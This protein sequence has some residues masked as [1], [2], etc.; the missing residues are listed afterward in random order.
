M[1][2]T[3]RRI[4]IA[5]QL[6]LT[7]SF[8][9][10]QSLD[11]LIDKGQHLL[12]AGSYDSA[13]IAFKKIYEDHRDVIKSIIGMADAYLKLNQYD[14]AFHF[15]ELA[16]KSLPLQPDTSLL[17]HIYDQQ[18]VGY[19]QIA[20]FEKANKLILKSLDLMLL[21]N[22]DSLMAQS[23]INLSSI[24]VQLSNFKKQRTYLELALSKATEHNQYR[25]MAIAHMGISSDM[26][27]NGQFDSARWHLQQSIKWA[28][29]L[30]NPL[31]K[32]YGYLNLAETFSTASEKEKH[33]F[34]AINAPGVPPFDQ[35][36]FRYF[37]AQFLQS[38][39]KFNKSANELYKVIDTT[40]SI[41]A[42]D[43]EMNAWNVLIEVLQGAGKYKD[44]TDAALKYIERNDSIF[45]KEM[46][47]EINTLNLKFETAIKE[48]ENEALR[49]KNAAQA[50]S[51]HKLKIK[52]RIRL[53]WL[54][55]ILSTLIGLVVSYIQRQKIYAKNK[56]I[57]MTEN[58][59]T[60]QKLLR[61]KKEKELSQLQ[62]SVLG[63]ENERKRLAQELHDG[64]GGLLS[65]VK[66]ALP[67]NDPDPDLA[68][69]LLDKASTELRQIAQ[70]LMPV[71]LNKFGLIAAIQ[72]LC[73]EKQESGLDIFFQSIQLDPN[74]LQ[75]IELHI[76][77]IVQELVNNAIKHAKASEILVQL[78]AHNAYLFITV[79]DNGIG[80]KTAL[81]SPKGHFGLDNIRSRLELLGGTMQIES[82]P[83]EGSS[84]NIQIP[85]QYD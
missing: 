40:T 60:E 72:D 54:G 47:Q 6:L 23:Y 17:I 5:A 81:Q 70:N 80:M 19:Q 49:A 68:I 25:E 34:L 53:L 24:Q 16:E 32:A 85:M 20:E 8:V 33:Y 4:L 39:G 79:E 37:Y 63:E 21:T 55:V 9:R 44:A 69:K 65:S 82:K 22:A 11:S 62:A 84:I 45:S 3:A 76:Y 18:G 26:R 10:A 83:N 58:V 61:L 7:C 30:G 31:L 74:A 42:D 77:R 14:S 71:N 13:L 43:L 46:R 73:N 38:Q 27:K 35:A 59:I 52:N 36:R 41:G 48:K 56:V 57:L 67:K 78:S 1:I 75:K 15:Y 64:L 66:L 29:T 50:L 2:V 12:D 28:E 51:I